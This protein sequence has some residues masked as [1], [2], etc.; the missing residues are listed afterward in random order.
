MSE[1]DQDPDDDT[2]NREAAVPLPERDA[3][4]ILGGPRLLPVEDEVPVVGPEN[5]IK[6]DPQPPVE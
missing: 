3:M 2:I 5:P 1:Q 6:V 4:S